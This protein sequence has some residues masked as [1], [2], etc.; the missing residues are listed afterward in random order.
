VSMFKGFQLKP[1]TKFANMTV[2]HVSAISAADVVVVIGGHI[3]TPGA[4]WAGIAL[5]KPVVLLRQFGGTG[6]ELWKDQ[7]GTYADVLKEEDYNG[8][9]DP[10]CDTPNLC[11]HTM[12]AC[13]T[14]LKKAQ[15]KAFSPRM[16]VL[17]SA[18]ALVLGF[19]GFLIAAGNTILSWRVF[20]VTLASVISGW[21]LAQLINQEKRGIVLTLPLAFLLSLV[22]V[23]TV[24]IG[25][26]VFEPFIKTDELSKD[27][28]RLYL[29]LFGSAL[30]SGFGAKTALQWWLKELG[31]K[32]EWGPSSSDER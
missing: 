18:I 11:R 1:H 19:S 14:L 5:T 9:N 10:S 20:A 21:M 28:S 25:G 15:Q 17:L 30:L 29:P 2:A 31:R 24:A 4:A 3:K 32:N 23:G 13:E 6:E 8:L 27:P 22:I 7:H 16:I 12:A 26:K